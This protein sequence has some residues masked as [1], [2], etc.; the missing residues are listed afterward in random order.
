MTEPLV[1]VC[2]PTYNGAKYL[3][4][5]ISSVLTQNYSNIEILI[6][7]QSSS[8]ETT[9]IIRSFSDQRLS[10]TILDA[11]GIAADNWNNCIANAKGK[12]VKLICQDDILK[13]YCIQ[14]QV[15][16]LE[17]FPDA[18]FCFS[19]R[20]IV[21]PKGKRLIGSRGWN[22][23]QDS[24][25]LEN[26]VSTLVRSG[27]NSFGEP[28]AVMMRGSNL[29]EAGKFEGSYLI[30]FNMWIKLLTIGP[31][32]F[33]NQS[34]SQF[35]IS[36]SSWTSKLGGQQAQQMSEAHLEL[37]KNFPT[38]ISSNDLEAGF[39]NAKKLESKRIFLTKIVSLLRL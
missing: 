21:S 7:D 10:Y 23:R 9:D 24:V 13:K 14:E 26:S 5:T 28:C 20:D 27:T 15:R 12:Y 8:D 2:I 29:R 25:T 22:P 11:T 31:A 38:L 18:S 6:S 30:D 1:S 16:K 39:K 37:Y 17:S 36:D 32:V 34:L 4:E 35:R 19:L 3:K 33:L